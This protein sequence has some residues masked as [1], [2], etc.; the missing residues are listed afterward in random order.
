MTEYDPNTDAR[1][2]QG[3]Q[4][5]AGGFAALDPAILAQAG[6]RRRNRNRALGAGAVAVVAVGAL[7]AGM[8][9]PRGP[10]EGTPEVLATPTPGIT[11][12]APTPT[13]AVEDVDLSIF[14]DATEVDEAWVEQANPVE[15]DPDAEIGDTDFYLFTDSTR[16][17]RCVMLFISNGALNVTC[18]PVEFIFT[19]PSEVLDQYC[20]WMP[21]GAYLNGWWAKPNEPAITDES[22]LGACQPEAYIFEEGIASFDDGTAQLAPGTKFTER[23]IT[24]AG[25]DDGIACLNTDTKAGFWLTRD[26][27]Q[28]WTGETTSAE[29]AA[30]VG[31]VIFPYGDEAQDFAKKALV[32]DDKDYGTR[33]AFRS[34]SGNILC[35]YW[36]GD[37][38]G[39]YCFIKEFSFDSAE[40]GDPDEECYA[41]AVGVGDVQDPGWARCMTSNEMPFGVGSW[42]GWDSYPVLPYGEYFKESGWICASA[43]SGISCHNDADGEDRYQSNGF[44]IS[45]DT[46]RTW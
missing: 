5:A 36:T 37:D 8:L 3:F 14:D 24:C 11:T 45:R 7:S 10:I 40:L 9:L 29:V 18:Q 16:N 34:P 41:V 22:H 46:L 32:S 13:V 6:R 19:P 12:S 42:D 35:E 31:P 2:K 39:A 20:T 1:L 44:Q 21:Q 4:D 33:W 30:T 26:R 27:Q 28:A 17:V 38:P 15:P 43:E 25:V 23:V